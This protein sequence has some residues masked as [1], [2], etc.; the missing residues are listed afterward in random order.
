MT[1]H[2]KTIIDKY[3]ERNKKKQNQYDT[4]KKILK[5]KLNQK[6]TEKNQIEFKNKKEIIIYL[7]SSMAAYEFRLKKENIINEIKTKIPTIR[8][9]KIEVK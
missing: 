8:K 4:I 5:E 7:N 6:V 9:I 2:I 3:I 1:E